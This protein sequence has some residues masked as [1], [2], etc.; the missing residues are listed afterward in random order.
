MT[1]PPPRLH[2][3]ALGRADLLR[4]INDHPADLQV[5]AL[6][7]GFDW[8]PPMPST[9]PEPQIADSQ[10][11]SSS[12][13]QALPQRPVLQATHFA[14]T[15]TPAIPS[16][17]GANSL[18]LD[19]GDVLHQVPQA[20]PAIQP[21][22]PQQLVPRRRM[23]SL[24]RRC[25]RRPVPSRQLD[26][27]EWIRQAT[28][29]AGAP[30]RLP[31]RRVRMWG[32]HSALVINGHAHSQPINADLLQ[33][34][35]DA[36]TWSAGAV[37]VY[38][39]TEEGLVQQAR[40]I[41]AAGPLHWR[42][43]PAHALQSSRHWL[44]AGASLTGPGVRPDFWAQHVGQV[45][46]NQ[47]TVVC[48]LAGGQPASNPTLPHGAQSV[49]WDHGARLQ[50]RSTAAGP[51]A[52]SAHGLDALLAAMS[53]AVRV[54]PA[55][56]RA[57]R[58]EL[59]LPMA[60]EVSAWAHADVSRHGIACT[61]RPE[62]V[63]RHR[64]WAA[65]HLCLASRQ[66]AARLVA[67]HHRHLPPWILME[68]AAVAANLA[69]GS[70]TDGASKAWLQMARTLKQVPGSPVAE[71][72]A[73]YVRRTGARSHPGLWETQPELAAAWVL[74]EREGLEAGAALPGGVPPHLL[75]RLLAR[76]RADGS[77]PQASLVQRGHGVWLVPGRLPQ[78]LAPVSVDQHGAL[79]QGP[80]GRRWIR[81]ERV[82]SEGVA[83]LDAA[84]GGPVHVDLD[85]RRLTL[86]PLPRPVWAD[87]WGRDARGIYAL[88]PPLGRAQVRLQVLNADDPVFAFVH[89]GQEAFQLPL[90][91]HDDWAVGVDR[92]GMFSRLVV[93]Q[94]LQQFRWI[95]PGHFLMGS[96]DTERARISDEN[97]RDLC[98]DEAPQHPVHISQGFWLADS[99][100]TQALWQAV[101]GDNP[102]HFKGKPQRPVEQVS[103]DDVQQ[104]LQ[105]LQPHL[106]AG[107][108][109]VLPTEAQW[110]YACR[111]GTQTAF[112]DGDSITSQQVNFDGDDG[113]GKSQ[114]AA[115]TVP[116]KSLPPNAW[117]LHEMHGNV[118]EWCADGLRSYAAD[119]EVDPIGRMET[120]PEAHHALRGG[121]WLSGARLARSAYRFA[122]RRGDRHHYLGFRL[123]LRST[124]PA[125]PEGQ[126]GIRPE[127]A[128][129]GQARRDA[130]P[131]LPAPE[132]FWDR[133][134]NTVVPTRRG[135]KK[136]KR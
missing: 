120:G 24:V 127:P 45:L 63:Q 74:A 12:F 11:P 133:I 59:G 135:N 7:C 80:A 75:T 87:E 108:E 109:A 126:Q 132:G 113:F 20:D 117:G 100:C 5:T 125:A 18:D 39:V 49:S 73:R 102:S 60:A 105:R 9:A 62:S 76:P 14:V 35:R 77:V 31:M 94:A 122:Y 25:L 131:K 30:A 65:Q 23:A 4:V 46:R 33:L 106:P 32:S 16:D 91:E 64:A 50:L 17:S 123:C 19:H 71:A 36:I 41:Q 28:R 82:G 103:W 136:P 111:S 134:V 69:P 56:L 86:K 47:G 15:V 97:L 115:A 121:S 6:L 2:R 118:F 48:L 40:A 119:A 61:L 8:Q 34:V 43:V 44:W 116:V 83:L 101:M 84:E 99:A 93:G 98:K 96:T 38:W 95:A 107:C 72:V 26:M 79:V 1:A 22:Q 54:E 81:A 66:H 13:A 52:T 57:L 37:R 55:L 51:T 130:G 129:R 3:A 70:G 68:E 42:A 29:G 114:G 67:L 53:L 78:Q 104:F 124:S 85:D 90:K 92:F 21:T 58:L 10:P 88:S 110:E 27:D 89:P 128:A 112:H